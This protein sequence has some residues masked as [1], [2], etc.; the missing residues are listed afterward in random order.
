MEKE[1]NRKS[2]NSK[3]YI[4]LAIAL[5]VIFGI[6]IAFLLYVSWPLIVGESIILDTRPV[7]PFDPL[8]GQ[9]FTIRYEISTIPIIE[10]ATEGSNIYVIL[11]EDEEGIS[12]YSSA[13]L[14]K[15]STDQNFLKG[16]VTSIRRGNLNIEYGIEQFFFERDADLP[17][18]G[19]QVEAKV[20]RSGKARISKL[21]QDGEPIAVEYK[22][23]TLTS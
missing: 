3:Q 8:R 5:A 9:Y 12:R 1:P 23:V 17:T 13:S 22:P 21:L 18:R 7:D 6:I 20:T 11:K 10:G 4:R 19:I 2:K 15:P 14:T 16:K